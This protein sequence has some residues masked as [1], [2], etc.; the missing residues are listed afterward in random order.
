MKL[1]VI[2]YPS[3]IGGAD[4]ELWHTLRVWRR[5]GADV[6][7]IPT[8]HA[9]P[10]W[11][12]RCDSI[13]VPT[14]EVGS[15]DQ[16][17]ASPHLRGATLVSFCNGE[18]L[19]HA[20]ACRTLGCGT[21]WV[22]CMNWIFPAERDH[23]ARQGVFDAYVFQSK[24]QKSRLLP[25]IVQFG[26]KEEQCFKVPGAFDPGEFPFSPRQHAA[27]ADFVVGRLARPDLDK[28]SRNTWSICA[29]IPFS[30]RRA[31]FMGWDHR[32]RGAVGE[33]PDWG[34]VLEPC[35]ESPQEFLSS[36][37]CLL[38]INGGAAENWPRVGLEAMSAG[39]PIIAENEWGWREMIQH[40][41][42]G[43]LAN[44]EQELAYYAAHLAMNEDLRLEMAANARQQLVSN[45]A[46]PHETWCR[47]RRV[48]EYVES[49]PKSPQGG[50]VGRIRAKSEPNA[51]SD[52]TESNGDVPVSDDAWREQATVDIST[53]TLRDAFNR[54]FDAGYRRAI[55]QNI[56]QDGIAVGT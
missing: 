56:R 16:L 5:F 9:P 37:H 53:M 3:D 4:T 38:A 55:K 51:V 23:Y 50:L 39:V 27:D 2:G 7:L 49:L 17:L 24:Y 21:V 29:S 46:D 14:I 34:E 10:A 31:R 26:G 25:E 47:W 30:R 32:V 28:W 35:A 1:C 33:P 45:L 18:F 43:F 12:T 11:R 36:L 41:K 52:I 44:N 15:A 48:F 13:G 22:G 54:G 42:T 8:W 40:G 20:D 6:K 19:R